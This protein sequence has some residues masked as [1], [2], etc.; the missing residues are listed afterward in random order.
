MGAVGFQQEDNCVGTA[1]HEQAPRLARVLFILG[2]DHPASL[3]ALP[4][5]LVALVP[6]Q[7]IVD[8][9]HEGLDVPQSVGHGGCR[10]VEVAVAQVGQQAVGGLILGEFAHEQCDPDGDAQ[11]AFGHHLRRWRGGDDAWQVGTGAGPA[12]ALPPVMP[13]VG[14]D[15]DFDD[16]AVIGA[17]KIGI[18][19]VAIGTAAL[20]LRQDNR[21]FHGG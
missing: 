9:L 12:I 3:V 13:A 2:K 8:G 11:Q 19:L 6:R 5:V 10:Q 1:Q 16:L 15:F 18:R 7:A 14:V 20:V 4:E 17:G 21:L